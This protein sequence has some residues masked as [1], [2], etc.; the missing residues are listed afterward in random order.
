MIS[1][2]LGQVFDSLERDIHR[3]ANYVADFN[4]TF[5]NYLISGES[6][7]LFARGSTRPKGFLFSKMFA[8]TVMPDYQVRMYAARLEKKGGKS[9]MMRLVRL[10][11]SARDAE[12]V[13]WTW[14]LLFG[15]RLS[16]DLTR[17]I[18]HFGNK[19][20]GIGCIDLSTG[21]LIH[22]PNQ[23]GKSLRSQMKLN[24]FVRNLTKKHRFSAI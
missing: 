11:E 15:D 1:S 2:D 5:R 21:T 4:E 18:E 14:L 16:E 23:L 17:Y 22:S 13:S 10:V 9:Q 7:R 12:R 6:F 8:I 20:V 3:R 19:E 24:E